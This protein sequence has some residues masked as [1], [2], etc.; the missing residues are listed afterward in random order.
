[1][2]NE[3]KA[4]LRKS[5]ETR[6][7]IPTLLDAARRLWVWILIRAGV[8]EQY[9]DGKG[10]P[11]IK[12]GRGTDRFAAHPNVVNRG[13]VHCRKCFT[14]GCDP[15]PGDGLA[16]IRWALDLDTPTAC[17][18]LAREL[19][20]SDQASGGIKRSPVIRTIPLD[21]SRLDAPEAF[22]ELAERCRE[23]MKP[24]W[25]NRLASLLNLPAESLEQLRVGWHADLRATTWRMVN[26]TGNVVGIWLRCPRT[27]RKWSVRGGQ[28]GLF[29][30]SMPIP[31]PDVLFVTEGPSDTAAVLSL[32]LP[33][34]GRASCNGSGDL[35]CDMVRWM[36]P[37][38][39][40]S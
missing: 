33:V 21:R 11:C 31:A 30:P 20:I 10:H 26:A 14:S 39:L 6:P 40:G 15:R 4:S 36:K 19:R 12:F 28:S 17:A 23:A 38:C 35:E 29:V 16:S 9:L 18:W 1:M 5:F 25:L 24:S 27:S 22:G 34:I 8:L 13:A 7:S 3:I 37:S 32:G 2:G